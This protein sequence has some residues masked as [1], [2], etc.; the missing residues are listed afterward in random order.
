MKTRGALKHLHAFI[1]DKANSDSG[2]EYSE[3]ITELEEILCNI[4]DQSNTEKNVNETG[5]PPI[6]FMTTTYAVPSSRSAFIS[7]F[8][9]AENTHGLS[10][11][12]N[13]RKAY[14]ENKFYDIMFD[15]GCALGSTGRMDQ[16]MAYCEHTG[17]SP[18]IDR[19]STVQVYF[20]K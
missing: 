11:Q 10:I 7:N 13:Q 18:N 9:E 15:S 12:V 19:S 6:S 5:D 3:A 2:D 8:R 14:G 1:T 17:K 16:Y 4:T 20:G